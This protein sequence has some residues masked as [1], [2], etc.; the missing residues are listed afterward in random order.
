MR[1]VSDK[2]WCK[3]WFSKQIFNK[4][5]TP[6]EPLADSPGEHRNRAGLRNFSNEL[7]GRFSVLESLAGTKRE[8]FQSFTRDNL[9]TSNDHQWSFCAGHETG[10]DLFGRIPPLPVPAFRAVVVR[11]L[12]KGTL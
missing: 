3:G 10:R 4:S 2:E 5:T 11:S 12:F 7:F 1:T 6:T 8:H 9:T